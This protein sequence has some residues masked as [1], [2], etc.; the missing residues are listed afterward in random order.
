MECPCHLT[1]AECKI[2]TKNRTM[3]L[4][5]KYLSE[6]QRNFHSHNEEKNLQKDPN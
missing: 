2:K 4:R 3:A 1:V 5:N 6:E